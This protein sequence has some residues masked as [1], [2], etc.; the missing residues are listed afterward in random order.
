MSNHNS[1]SATTAFLGAVKD[2]GL[3]TIIGTETGDCPTG[4]GQNLYFQ[5][6]NS[7]LRC[8]SS[9]TFMIRINGDTDMTHGVIP[10]YYIEQTIED[11]VKN[12]DT[13]LNYTFDLIDKTKHNNVY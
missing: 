9:T 4:F 3:G 2:Y 12:I 11:T 5:L 13:I 10:D 1:Y 8:H 7:S 6:S